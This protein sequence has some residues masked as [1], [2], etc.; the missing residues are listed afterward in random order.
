MLTPHHLPLQLYYVGIVELY[1][2]EGKPAED[3]LDLG[4]CIEEREGLQIMIMKSQ[5]EEVLKK[6]KNKKA[7]GID[8]I[9]AEF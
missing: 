8:E 7:K 2:R 3:Q 6:L 1:D 9:P 4:P 5:F